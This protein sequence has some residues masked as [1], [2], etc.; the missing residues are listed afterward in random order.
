MAKMLTAAAVAKLKPL[1]G[2]RREVPDAGCPGL[3]LV[4][5]PSGAK[6]WAMR[7][8]RPGGKTAKL[9]LGTCDDTGGG[10]GEPTLGG[11]LTLAGARRLAADVRHK[12]ASGHD[13]AAN[14]MEEKKRLRASPSEAATTFGPAAMD[15]IREHKVRKIGER[16]RRWREI[17][18]TLGL[19]YL[20][21][22]DNT[23][24]YVKG[25]LAERWR[26]RPVGEITDLDV[27]NVITESRKDGI[28]GM[29][30]KNKGASDARGRRMADALGSMFRRLMK[31]R[32]AAMRANP[33][34]DVPRPDAAR[35]RTRVLNARLDVRRADE[36]RWFW[37]ACDE[38]SEPFGDLL[39]LLLLTGCRRD[40]LARLTGDELSDDATT[41]M[42]P[43]SRTKNHLPHDIF[44]P[45]TAVEIMQRRRERKIENC[46]FLFSTTGY[47][48]VSGFS[49]IK[50][51]LDELMLRLAQEERGPDYTIP[52]WELHD[53]RRTFST[54]L[55]DI[56]I[57]PHI[58]EACINHVSGARAGVAG[59]Y[60]KAQYAAERKEALAAWARHV[61]AIVSANVVPMRRGA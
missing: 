55:N 47:S 54:G 15:F 6:S 7:Y 13:P 33:C 37:A 10:E 53:L 3:H 14:W 23:P 24:T 21:D 60:N 8:R 30:R 38:V 4:I 20:P 61:Q 25:G 59:T 12:I 44:L 5:Q 56:G 17:A 35:S 36:L 28:P 49:K 27:H 29:Q 11:H 57:P 58:V 26:D 9:T 41:I 42:L 18:R 40:E 46:K 45:P 16:P 1:V 31:N 34:T 50:H 19:D 32:R 39:R 51:R 48:A 2:G 52:H 22:D 43:G